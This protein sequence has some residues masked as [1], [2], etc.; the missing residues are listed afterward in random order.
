GSQNREAAVAPGGETVRREPVD[1]EIAACAVVTV[2]AHDGSATGLEPRI[3]GVGQVADL[4]AYDLEARRA[5]EV[6][7][8]VGLVGADAGDDPAI[9]LLLEEPRRARWTIEPMR[10]QADRLQHAT[11]RTGLHQ[12]G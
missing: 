7:E 4:R 3:L 1:A 5:G 11:D 8:V 2:A 6:Q 10:P 12:L 9:A